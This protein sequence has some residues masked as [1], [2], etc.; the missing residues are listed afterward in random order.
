MSLR[1]AMA[2]HFGNLE[3]MQGG[4]V[5]TP[6][7]GTSTPTPGTPPKQETDPILRLMAN[8]HT[9]QEYNLVL[10]YVRDYLQ[11]TPIGA[12][13]PSLRQKQEKAFA[14]LVHSYGVSAAA[15]VTSR[16]VT[17]G[18]AGGGTGGSL[19]S[20][21]QKIL[22]QAKGV[23]ST[24]GEAAKAYFSPGGAGYDNTVGGDTYH[25]PVWR[26][27]ELELMQRQQAESE[28]TDRATL[29]QNMG[30]L[31]QAEQQSRRGALL[32]AAQA[33]F[34]AAGTAAP[35]G[36]TTYPGYEEGGS[37]DVLSKI[38]GTTTPASLKAPI[39]RKPVSFDVLNA[40]DLGP[41]KEQIAAIMMGVQGAKKGL[42]SMADGGSTYMDDIARYNAGVAGKSPD[43]IALI[44][45][46]LAG[47]GGG[48][49]TSANSLDAIIGQAIYEADRR[50]RQIEAELQGATIPNIRNVIAQTMGYNDTGQ[51]TMDMRQLLANTK[52]NPRNII[53][54]LFLGRGMGLPADLSNVEA[55][56]GGWRVPGST[57]D[58]GG[59]STGGGGGTAA[60]ERWQ[61]PS[62][63]WW[64]SQGDYDRQQTRNTAQ[65]ASS[66]DALARMRAGTWTGKMAAEGKVVSGPA[67]STVGERGGDA[68]TEYAFL[69]PGAVVAPKPAGEKPN[70][71]GALRAIAAQLFK[72]GLGGMATGGSVMGG[73]SGMGYGS[74]FRWPMPTLPTGSGGPAPTTPYTPADPIGRYL[75]RGGFGLRPYTPV[76]PIDQRLPYG[77]KLPLTVPP[78]PI[79][80]LSPTPESTTPYTPPDPI[81]RRLPYGVKTLPSFPGPVAPEPTY[82]T[83][84]PPD[85]D[86]GSMSGIR[87][88]I[89]GIAGLPGG[90]ALPG[91]SMTQIRLDTMAR[92]GI[93]QAGAGLTSMDTGGSVFSPTVTGTLPRSLLDAPALRAFMSPSNAGLSSIHKMPALFQPFG[94]GGPEAPNWLDPRAILAY[95]H[96]DPTE[97]G[98]MQSLT[99]AFG[100]DPATAL[101]MARRAMAGFGKPITGTASYRPYWSW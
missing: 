55:V 19:L 67:I 15:P 28:A 10:P 24:L 80:P 25:P 62:G 75:P 46:Y 52:A 44:N 21:L 71:D 7:P 72:S 29:L 1:S 89:M 17:G 93:P 83:T 63:S 69:P 26:E 27:G 91:D 6:T 36:M 12:T 70:M 94:E 61:A 64:Q 9:R 4:G 38:A 37:A 97:Q 56:E 32:E 45:R 18:T 58:G 42:V 48:T 81:D 50:N 78:S 30:Q 98:V 77:I 90:V 49:G 47:L 88:R 3:R 68:G 76:D 82:P 43:E 5:A 33:L 51:P 73:G 8:V 2:E 95:A 101:E 79:R 100:N 99:S 31:E 11:K 16:T 60:G 66:A 22:G 41:L 59:G 84:M 65:R 14:A 20:G 39:T 74:A 23:S 13:T 57:D 40:F 92:A 53:E 96:A 34:T 35:P 54:G 86:P 85:I 87:L